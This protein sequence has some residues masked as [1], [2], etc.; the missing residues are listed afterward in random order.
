MW[1]KDINGRQNM[2]KYYLQQQLQLAVTVVVLF[3]V[4][5]KIVCAYNPRDSENTFQIKQQSY[6]TKGGIFNNVC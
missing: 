5:Q 1:E 3:L 6:S 4:Q 2:T